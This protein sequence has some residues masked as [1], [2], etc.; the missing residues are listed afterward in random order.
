MDG[1]MKPGGRRLGP[2]SCVVAMAKGLPKHMQ[3]E[4]R[5]IQML[6][7]FVEKQNQGYATSLMHEICREADRAG[8]ILVLFP[9]P[10]NNTPIDQEQLIQWYSKFGFQ[11]TQMKPE[12]LMARPVGSTPRL[13]KPSGTAG[14]VHEALNGK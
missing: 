3:P 1:L 14:A 11:I 8:K 6:Q 13:L 2:A 10:F 4:V 5:E 12:T 9:K 7:T